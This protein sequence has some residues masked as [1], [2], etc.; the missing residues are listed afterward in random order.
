MNP[1]LLKFLNIFLKIKIFFIQN[2]KSW[3]LDEDLLLLQESLNSPNKWCIIARKLPKRNQHQI[4][5]R[6]IKLLNKELN[7][8]REKIREMMKEKN[9]LAAISIALRNLENKKE[10]TIRESIKR[11][12]KK[13]ENIKKEANLNNLTEK[14]E[15]NN[16]QPIVFKEEN[17][18]NSQIENND[19]Y[20]FITTN[21]KIEENLILDF[22]KN[23]LWNCYLSSFFN[24]LNFYE[25]P[26]KNGKADN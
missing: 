13:E 5:N 9:I 23:L 1:F 22:Q 14:I 15:N 11:E 8:R 12:I 20:N 19:D 17:K 25:S 26:F 16:G 6:F 2:R 3:S 7:L 21:P 24:P 18:Q 4:K 10:E